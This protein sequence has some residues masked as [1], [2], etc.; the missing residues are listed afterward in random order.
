MTTPIAPVATHPEFASRLKAANLFEDGPFYALRWTGVSEY[1]G[2]VDIPRAVDLVQLL[3]GSADG[4][5]LLPASRPEGFR[6]ALSAADP[7]FASGNNALELGLLAGFVLTRLWD[8][9]KIESDVAD[10]AALAVITW[11]F[12]GRADGTPAEAFVRDAVAYRERRSVE[13]SEL[14]TVAVL[15]RAARVSAANFAAAVTAA[16]SQSWA[17][18]S[19][20]FNEIAAAVNALANGQDELLDHM[21]RALQSQ[22]EESNVAWWVLGEYSRNFD[23]HI[24]ALSPSGAPIILGKEL[25]ELAPTPPGSYSARAILDR[26]LK[27][28]RA[29]INPA[30][31]PKNAAGK[32]VSDKATRVSLLDM[33]NAADRDW[34]AAWTEDLL[35][36]SLAGPLTPVMT[37]IKQSMAVDGATE[38]VPQYTKSTKGIDPRLPFD[39]LTVAVQTYNEYVLASVVA[40]AGE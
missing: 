19:A 29:S 6:E 21:T 27:I 31:R 10:A 40:Q 15:P 38:W 25:G 30:T 23:I 3:A 7:G 36:A 13:M 5:T 37:A 28:H 16:A 20:A 4:A 35:S 2:N 39:P 11:N 14:T 32:T 24:G 26:M 12:W 18:M 34:R 1:S 9:R 8:D 22:R 33:V 17:A